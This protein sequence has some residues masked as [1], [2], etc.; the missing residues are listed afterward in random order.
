M[1]ATCQSLITADVRGNAAHI[2]SLMRQARAAGARL[3]HFPEGA[4]TG[5][6]KHQIR[7]WSAVDW[8][9]VREEF[10]RTAA[11]AGE[12]ELWVVVGGAH[13]L[14]PPH[15]PHNSLYVISD[16]GELVG[17]YDKRFLSNT[18][19]TSFYTPGFEPLVFE[20]DGWRFGCAICIETVFPALFA[21]YERLDVDAVLL[22]MYYNL[23]ER[24]LMAQAHASINSYWI[25]YANSADC[26]A[27]S[28]SA[29]YGPD[30]LALGVC[31]GNGSAS[32]ICTVLDPATPEFDVPLTKARPWRRLASAGE[33]YRQRRVDDERSCDQTRF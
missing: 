19:V 16:S 29:L 27:V 6:A 2:R 24:N 5:Y 32:L 18:E 17:R 7:D 23:P 21:E 31:E 3:A 15:W 4:L 14:T 28:P 11:L 33:I 8:N 9:V 30:G 1:L 20:V 13:R 26:S 22:S 12:L 25:S 10:K